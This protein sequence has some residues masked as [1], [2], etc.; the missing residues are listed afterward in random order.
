[1]ALRFFGNKSA[2][3]QK[4]LAT[5]LALTSEAMS[6]NSRQSIGKLKPERCALLVCD[7]QERFTSLITGFDV[8]VDTCRR[9]VLVVPDPDKMLSFGGA[10]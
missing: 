9:M 6:N 10:T 4:Y 2:F 8:V 5:E 7:V 1:M 3:P